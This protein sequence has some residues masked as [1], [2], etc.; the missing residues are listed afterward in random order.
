VKKKKKYNSGLQLLLVTDLM[1]LVLWYFTFSP[2][3]FIT[4]LKDRKQTLIKS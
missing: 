4:I 1:T 2:I 3:H